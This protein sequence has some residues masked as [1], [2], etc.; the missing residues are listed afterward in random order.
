VLLAAITTYLLGY[1]SDL[2]QLFL[3][4]FLMGGGKVMMASGVT[5]LTAHWFRNNFGLALACCYAGWHFGGLVMVPLTQWLIDTVGWRETTSIL[6][7]AIVAA[8]LPPLAVWARAPSPVARGVEPETGRPMPAVESPAAAAGEDARLVLRHPALWLSIGISVL[9]S[10]AYGALLTNQAVLVDELPVLEGLG[11]A[12]VSVTALSAL[13][14]ALIIGWVSDRLDFRPLV[15]LELGLLCSGVLGFLA[16]YW[17]PSPLLLFA[18]AISFGISV[19]GFEAAV[20]P[21]LRRT[22]SSA[23]FDR[24]FGVWYF[25]YLA[26]LFAAPIMAGWIYDHFGSYVPA[27]LLLTATTVAAVIPAMFMP[28]SHGRATG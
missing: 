18:A 7:L 23:G 24:A 13:C 21:N 8:A 27:L 19:G 3:L 11:S 9:G 26:A 28:P 15:L 25:C 4:R 14:G 5:L 22:L 20:L 6:G 1:C 2:D 12:A 10:I 16:L 17:L